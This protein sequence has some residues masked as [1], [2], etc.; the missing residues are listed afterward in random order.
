MTTHPAPVVFCPLEIEARAARKAV[1]SSCTIIRTGPGPEAIRR[2]LDR[3]EMPAGAVAIL[4]GTAGGLTDTG[5]AC[6]ASRVIDLDARSWDAAHAAGITI[7][8]VNAPVCK[9]L[10]KQALARRTNAAV[11]D[12]ESHIF[13]P[14]ANEHGWRWAIV[15]GITDDHRTDLSPAIL[16]WVTSDGRTALRRVASSMLRDPRLMTE[17]IRLSR[18]TSRALRA[19]GLL[20]RQTIDDLSSRPMDADQS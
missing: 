5:V 1:A 8:G 16:N 14:L 6:R 3:V 18:R 9:A 19:A 13:A 10:E 11:V 15:R 12:C 17:A 4:F 20:L 2:A 7:A